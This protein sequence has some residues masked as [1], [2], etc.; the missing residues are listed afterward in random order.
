[1][2]VG[3]DASTCVGR[4]RERNLVQLPVARE[5]TVF[6]AC[7]AAKN[8]THAAG[9]N[10][11]QVE[12]PRGTHQRNVLALGPAAAASALG[13]I[14]G[15]HLAAGSRLGADSPAADSPAA[16]S[17]AAFHPDLVAYSDKRTLQRQ[18]SCS[19]S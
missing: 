6:S 17:P 12:S 8:D 1:M 3:V 11:L 16:D 19:P 2:S 10:D 5:H 7:S 15:I 18:G 14:S 13:D 4:S 9:Q